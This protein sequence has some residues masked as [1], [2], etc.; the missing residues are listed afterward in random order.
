MDRHISGSGNPQFGHVFH[1]SE[2]ICKDIIL[3][4]VANGHYFMY[5]YTLFR[6]AMKKGWSFARERTWAMRA[7]GPMEQL[8]PAM[9]LG[10]RITVES[11]T[12]TWS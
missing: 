11:Q 2:L 9:T 6:R 5:N 12:K 1:H 7:L 4:R 8:G 3:S 10:T